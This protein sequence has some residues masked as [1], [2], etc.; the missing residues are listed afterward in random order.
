[1]SS[2]QSDMPGLIPFSYPQFGF[3]GFDF[4]GPEDENG[5]RGDDDPH[6]QIRDFLFYRLS[7]ATQT[8]I[9][10]YTEL[11]LEA[12]SKALQDLLDVGDLEKLWCTYLSSECG[13]HTYVGYQLTDSCHQEMIR[14]NEDYEVQLAIDAGEKKL[15]P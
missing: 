2:R 7:G 15:E 3:A 9:S 4:D 10:H 12:V 5:G 8:V 13:V 6:D 11:T 1:M 14:D